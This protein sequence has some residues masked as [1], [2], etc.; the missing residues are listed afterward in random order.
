[1]AR[2]S[3]QQQ[4]VDRTERIERRVDYLHK[5]I[6]AAGDDWRGLSYAIAEMAA[7]EWALRVIKKTSQQDLIEAL[8]APED[9]E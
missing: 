2:P 4:V 9:R 3:R 8:R 1:M 5:Q 6:A 7:L